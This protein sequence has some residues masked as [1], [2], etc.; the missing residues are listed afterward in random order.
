MFYN[1]TRYT[2]VSI[3]KI[4]TQLIGGIIN[5]LVSV[6]AT[7]GSKTGAVFIV[8]VSPFLPTYFDKSQGGAYPHIASS[9]P[10]LPLLIQYSWAL[11]ADD[12]VFLNEIKSTRDTLLQMVIAQGQNVGGSKQ[13]VYPN[14]ALDD[15]PLSQMY[16][17]NQAK[18]QSIR[19]AWDPDNVMYLTGGF[20]F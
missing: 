20:K 9:T 2:T 12:Q 15:T 11:P 10:L 5:Q 4:T 6:N 19:Q 7:L 3:T 16:G 8:Y 17:N 18:L 14:Y 1:R 13:I